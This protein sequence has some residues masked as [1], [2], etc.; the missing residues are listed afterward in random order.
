MCAEAV[1]PSLSNRLNSSRHRFKGDLQ[2]WQRSQ[3]LIYL[4]MLAAYCRLYKCT[5]R[6]QHVDF[7]LRSGPCS[8]LSETRETSQPCFNHLVSRQYGDADTGADAGSEAKTLVV[9][10]LE[11]GS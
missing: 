5:P 10:S 1:P 4:E 3:L 7:C 6:Y 2:L 11:M 8:K 9:P